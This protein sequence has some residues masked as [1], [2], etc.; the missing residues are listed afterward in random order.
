MALAGEGRN[1]DNVMRWLSFECVVG[2]LKEFWMP[3]SS[4]FADAVFGCW[5]IS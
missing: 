3:V 5:C 4:P 1:M 2:S